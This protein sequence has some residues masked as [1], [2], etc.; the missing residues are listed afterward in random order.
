MS[1]ER[2]PLGWL[3]PR[4]V[5]LALVALAWPNTAQAGDMSIALE[6]RDGATV[7]KLRSDQG[8][9][10]APHVAASADGM[11]LFFEGERVAPSRS[12]AEGG[13]LGYVQSGGTVDRAAIRLVQRGS[14]RGRLTPHVRRTWVPGGIDIEVLDSLFPSSAAP[15]ADPLAPDDAA[16][17]PPS[18]ERLPAAAG[19]LDGATP[20]PAATPAQPREGLEALARDDG[21]LAPTEPAPAPALEPTAAA[22]APGAPTQ[23]AAG[24]AS[25][26]PL[27]ATLAALADVGTPPALAAAAPP[28]SDAAPNAAAAADLAAAA[29]GADA[30]ATP[31]ADP[32]S[33]AAGVA[34]AGI[35]PQSFLDEANAAAPEGQARS[36]GLTGPTL[37]ILAILIG[38]G[39]I[40][41]ALTR[42]RRGA[43]LRARIELLDHVAVGPKQKVV[44]VRVGG[45]ELLLG[46]T[47]KDIRLLADVSAGQPAGTPGPAP[48]ADVAGHGRPR[49]DHGPSAAATSGSSGPSDPP[50]VAAAALERV[51]HRSAAPAAADA[52]LAAH[53]AQAQRPA[54]TRGAE[55]EVSDRVAAF[56]ARLRQALDQEAKR[57]ASPAEDGQVIPFERTEPRWARMPGATD[58]GEI[59]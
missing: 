59:A 44:C 21:P 7:I 5:L 26:D 27:D 56:K 50:W 28:T 32:P 57:T 29:P 40:A 16:T 20:S 3:R 52:V 55:Q 49:A 19:E 41:T 22:D 24:T 1:R 58:F 11:I 42:R 9:L 6:R 43:D 46:A 12:Y 33:P 51:L 14:A 2:H 54:A 39:A 38:S 17:S 45:R 25:D 35:E 53:E 13:R 15:P 31:L 47:D 30:D 37:A 4:L 23:D 10:P 48:A 36:A 18:A 8:R 34:V